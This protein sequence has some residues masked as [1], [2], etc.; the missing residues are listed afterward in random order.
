MS[1]GAGAA[2]LDYEAEGMYWEWQHNE[3][4]GNWAPD[5][6]ELPL[7]FG[8]SLLVVELISQVIPDLIY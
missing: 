4:N 8:I 6:A 7:H 5:T 1:V 3:R 2:I